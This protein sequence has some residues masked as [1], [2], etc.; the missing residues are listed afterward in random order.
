MEEVK[1]EKIK[2]TR[3]EYERIKKEMDEEKN[4]PKDRKDKP[5]RWK[6]KQKS[7]LNKSVKKP[8]EIC[9][10]V[11]NLKK[12]IDV[13]LTR[14]YGGNFL[15][16]RHRV[17]RYN[18]NRVYSMGKYKVVIAR[19]YDRELVGIDDYEQ[20]MREEFLSKNPGARLNIDDPVLIK[21]LIQAKLSE[22]PSA[23][24]NMKWIIVVLV[25][26]GI[27]V[28]AFFLLGGNKGAKTDTTN[29]T[30]ITPTN[31]TG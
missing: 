18:P 3:E 23:G 14:I 26:L 22:K 12:Q 5:F 6:G 16:I 20:L 21:A 10:I 24:A 25:I 8:D 2:I 27:I 28:G 1:K 31:A 17:Y 15:V 19:E 13:V 9:A 4:K 7:N 29:S 11:I 30:V